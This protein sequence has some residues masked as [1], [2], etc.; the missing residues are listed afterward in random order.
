VIH[1]IRPAPCFQPLSSYKNMMSYLLGIDLGT[2]A[3]KAVIID[4]LGHV[5][6]VGSRE[7][8]IY[9]PQSGFAEQDPEDWWRAACAAVHEACTAANDLIGFRTEAIEAIGFSGQMH[10]PVFVKADGSP[11]GNAIIWADQRTSATVA[12]IIDLVGADVFARVAGTAPA[13]GFM[14]ATLFWLQQH[15]PD[16]LAQT[17]K[18]LLPK[19]YLRLRLTGTFGTDVSDASATALFDIQK[20]TWSTDIIN[21]LALPAHLW[22]IVN[23][24]ADVVGTLTPTAAQALGLPEGIPVV[25]G[26]ADQPAQAVGSGLIDPGIGSV[27]IGSGGQLFVPLSQPRIDPLGRLHTFC[28]A[29]P[30]RWYFLGAM[31]SA[32]LSMR[33][34]RDIT[35][36]TA[37]PHAYE[38][39]SALAAKVPPGADGLLFLPYLIG[40]RA[41]I[42]DAGATGCFIGLTLNHGTGHLA[43]AVM[44]GIAY[45]LRQMLDEIQ[46]LDVS[47]SQL[48]AA[49]GGLSSTVWRQIVADI[50]DQP[51]CIATRNERSG[52]GAGLIAGLGM[53]IYKSYRDIHD[54]LNEPFTIVDP[55]P[56]RQAIYAKGYQRFIRIY[57]AVRSLTDDQ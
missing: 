45:N 56:K 35:G 22:P 3:V 33:W 6:G 55:D 9:A 43:R 16:R 31:L 32:G 13:V 29:V 5:C 26:C 28:H 27:T 36:L 30:D 50:L 4:E 15:D 42:R 39:L 23:E 44:E 25:A 46:G 53:G 52:V 41:P 49:G 1:T 48:V 38:H 10:G 24:S 18:V 14:A 51:L 54:L 8:P 2:S 17:Y 11:L 40:E 57:P 34:L 7:Y 21:T 47:V 12:Q 37:D 19:D 20:R